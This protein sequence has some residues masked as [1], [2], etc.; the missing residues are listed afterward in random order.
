MV[1]STK[2][3]HNT[4]THDLRNH[5]IDKLKQAILPTSDQDTTFD[6]RMHNFIAYAQKCEEEIYEAANSK[7]DYY[8]LLAEKIYD[9]QN[10]L[11]ERRQKRKADQME[12]MDYAEMAHGQSDTTS[13]MDTDLDIKRNTNEQSGQMQR[14]RRSCVVRRQQVRDFYVFLVFVSQNVTQV[15]DDFLSE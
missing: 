14:Q 5:L 12:R 3:W 1:S 7:T 8:Y 15:L 6:G 9:I 10:G 2:D 13:Q 4:I 11:K